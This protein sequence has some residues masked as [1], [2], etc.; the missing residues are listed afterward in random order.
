VLIFYDFV[1][2]MKELVTLNGK[3][4]RR[5]VVLNEVEMSKM[6]GREAAEGKLYLVNNFRQLANDGVVV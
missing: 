3:E 6:I 2:M 1:T 5:L 4:Q